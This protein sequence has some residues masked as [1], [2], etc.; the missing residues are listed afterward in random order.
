MIE[1]GIY[2]LIV[3]STVLLS[4]NTMPV[5]FHFRKNWRD[6]FFNDE[7]DY[8]KSNFFSSII[9]STVFTIVSIIY[10]LSILDLY[11]NKEW[12]AFSLIILTV[13]LTIKISPW[14][15]IDKNLQDNIKPYF[16]NL[17]TAFGY[18]LLFSVILATINYIWFEPENLQ[19]TQPIDSL[20]PDIY[21]IF[22][23]IK[24]IKS[25]FY[26]Q[27]IPYLD[28]SILKLI[29][30]FVTFT[31]YFFI[32]YYTSI[33]AGTC[34]NIQ[35]IEDKAIKGLYPLFVSLVIMVSIIFGQTDVLVGTQKIIEGEQAAK[36]KIDETE[37]RNTYL[38][39]T[40]EQLQNE[41]KKLL[42][43]LE[44]KTIIIEEAR[45]SLDCI[46]DNLTWFN[47]AKNSWGS[48]GR[49]EKLTGCKVPKL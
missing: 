15:I 23:S 22:V 12:I 17:I 31:Q 48:D 26:T 20:E 16:N 38:N 10:V 13:V 9:I 47:V 35:L 4:L 19:H 34:K 18:A 36:D 45:H 29:S 8:F 40:T 37:K 43:E 30:T 7:N 39:M 14:K 42:Y 49:I 25:E 41:N 32:L 33:L 3:V 2:G 1:F 11:Y 28:P 5:S 24:N 27:L 21:K 44:E 46:E 6:S